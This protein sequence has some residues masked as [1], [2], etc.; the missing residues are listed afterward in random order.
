MNNGTCLSTVALAGTA[1]SKCLVNVPERVS[2]RPQLLGALFP[3]LNH[4]SPCY[5]SERL[6]HIPWACLL[7]SVLTVLDGYSA[8]GMHFSVLTRLTSRL[9][10]KVELVFPPWS[11]TFI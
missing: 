4:P 9:E 6:G 1:H 11:V 2:L 10:V 3:S 7:L 5:T 8:L